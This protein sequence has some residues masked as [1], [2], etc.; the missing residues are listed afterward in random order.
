M[1]VEQ[2]VE[3]LRKQYQQLLE[4]DKLAI[5]TSTIMR[6]PQ[7]QAQIYETMF[8]EGVLSFPPPDRYKLRVLK[9]IVESMEKAIEDPDEDVGCP[10][11]ATFLFCVCFYPHCINLCVC[12]SS[13][14]PTLS[15]LG[16]I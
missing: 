6:K 10:Y 9:K 13:L 16:N 7:I 1:N 4:P 2:E 8:K 14:M 3:L 11:I 12:S 15:P 5:P